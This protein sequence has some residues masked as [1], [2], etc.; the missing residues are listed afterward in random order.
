MEGGWVGGVGGR[1]HQCRERDKIM[2]LLSTACH[3]THLHLWL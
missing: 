2:S 3:E 1:T